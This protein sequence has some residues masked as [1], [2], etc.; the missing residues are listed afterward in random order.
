M[1]F[2]RQRSLPF[3][4]PNL[5][6]RSGSPSLLGGAQTTGAQITGA[7]ISGRQNSERQNSG[8]LRSP[9]RLATGPISGRVGAPVRALREPT[10]G[11]RVAVARK[12]SQGPKP[13]S[14]VGAGRAPIVV[15]APKARS[16][17][18]PLEGAPGFSAKRNQHAVELVGAC[19][20]I[21]AFL[22]LALF[23]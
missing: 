7:Q 23:G 17:A 4:N 20:M 1:M 19:M 2:A 6:T 11:G 18:A 8:T 13:V 10:N 12:V 21:A 15:C 5:V 16:E 22:V 9:V 3:Q 14:V